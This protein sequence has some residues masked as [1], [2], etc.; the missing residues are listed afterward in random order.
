MNNTINNNTEMHIDAVLTW[1]NGEDKAWQEKINQYLDEK[2]DFNKKTQ[3][4]RYNSIGEIDIAIQSIIKFA[5][6]VKNIFLITDNQKPNTFD[7]LKKLAD[8]QGINLT[9]VDHQIIFKGYEKYLPTFNSRSIENMMF[10]IPD[11]SE[12]YIYFNDDFCLM[13]KTKP[14]D[15]FI[16]GK[17]ILRGKWESFYE[18]RKIRQFFIKI[19]KAKNPKDR[20]GFKGGQQNAARLAGTTNYLRRFHTPVPIRKSTLVNFFNDNDALEKNINYRFRNKNQFL[21]TSLAEHL[22]IANNTFHYQRDTQLTYFRSYKYYFL[23]KLKLHL[24]L[25]NKKNLFMT[26]Q[27]LELADIKIQKYIFQWIEKRLNNQ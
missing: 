1:V 8:I 10:K 13:R 12:H 27:S 11:L 23:V 16:D 5:S 24:F 21:V 14:D 26:F 7:H 18:D 9:I 22:E 25:K 20:T 19:F 6:F 2:I 4:V 15:F 3:S 17:P